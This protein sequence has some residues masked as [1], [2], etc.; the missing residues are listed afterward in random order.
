[1]GRF[2]GFRCRDCGDQ[3]EVLTGTGRSFPL[4]Y[5]R[6]LRLAVEGKY[7]EEIRR[8]LEE[9]P[10]GALDC[11]RVLLLCTECGELA[12][13][14]DLS[15]YIPG[16]NSAGEEKSGA[17]PPDLKTYRL[18]RSCEHKCQ[19]GGKMKVIRGEELARLAET[20]DALNKMKDF[21][22]SECGGQLQ[23]TAG[24]VWD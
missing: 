4:V 12:N 11:E 7:G 20:E 22:C 24:T 5:G 1:M 8:F 16:E 6:T 21:R 3:F 17:V 19:C 13:G 15:M 10:D 23:L 9:H 14:M 2:F 18:I